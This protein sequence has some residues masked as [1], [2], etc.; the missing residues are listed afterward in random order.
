MREDRLLP[1]YNHGD[2]RRVNSDYLSVKYRIEKAER[3][4]DRQPVK[5]LKQQRRLIPSGDPS[6]AG[7]RRLRYVRYCDDWLLGF[8][9]PKR[10]FRDV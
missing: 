4:G 9:G 10:A 2:H 5:L 7:F 1:V 6:D 3:R 8:T